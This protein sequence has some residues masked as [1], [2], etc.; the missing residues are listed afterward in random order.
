MKP[1]T[2]MREN[3]GLKEESPALGP[4]SLGMD[5]WRNARKVYEH[6]GKPRSEG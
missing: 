5:N 1:F 6:S 4:D 2:K 3:N